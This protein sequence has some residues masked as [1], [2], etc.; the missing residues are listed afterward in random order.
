MGGLL[1]L[2]NMNNSK[3]GTRLKEVR[4]DLKKSQEQLALELGVT[5]QAISNI[6]N[7]KSMPSIQ[8]LS[9]LAIDYNV[10]LN[11]LIC[12]IGKMY[13]LNQEENDDIKASVI[14]QV[15]QLLN[16]RGIL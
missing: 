6:E 15:E 2:R 14:A 8:F 3:L 11:Y 7:S 13:N 9:K 1:M 4:T 12:G 10:N 16:E 5:K